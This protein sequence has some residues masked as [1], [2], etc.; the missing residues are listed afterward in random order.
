MDNSQIGEWIRFLLPL[1]SIFLIFWLL[2]VRPQR[3]EQKIKQEMLSSL[4][5]GDEILTIGG[6][7]GKV[8]H[9]KLQEKNSKEDSTVT[10]EIA[11][12]SHMKVLLNSIDRVIKPIITKDS[13][14]E[15]GEKE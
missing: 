6:I 13:M 5:K 9:V 11:E 4:K 3:R 14:K 12:G 2:I 10:I 1:A 8:K 15:K 7:F